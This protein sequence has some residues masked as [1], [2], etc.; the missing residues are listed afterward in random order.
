MLRD[1]KRFFGFCYRSFF[2]GFG[3]FGVQAARSIH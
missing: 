1:A 2:M 3:L